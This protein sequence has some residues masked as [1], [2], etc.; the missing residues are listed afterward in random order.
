MYTIGG[1]LLSEKRNQTKT[2]KSFLFS[3]EGRC[4][5]VCPDGFYGDEDSNDCEECHSDCVTC[6]GPEDNDCLSCEERKT[7]ENGECVSDHEVCPTK[8]FRS[9]ETNT[10]VL[11]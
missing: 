4:V 5:S 7:L 9:G 3:S 8:T 10:Y 2:I 1:G 11:H 6:S